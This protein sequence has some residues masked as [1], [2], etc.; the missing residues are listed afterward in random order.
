MLVRVLSGTR[1][2]RVLVHSTGTQ[3][4]RNCSMR[5]CTRWHNQP[6]HNWLHTPHPCTCFLRVQIC[7]LVDM[8]GTAW[9]RRSDLPHP[10]PE[11]PAAHWKP[12]QDIPQ[13]APAH[14]QMWMGVGL[15]VSRLMTRTASA[16]LSMQTM[17]YPAAQRWPRQSVA[18]YAP[19][20]LSPHSSPEQPR[21]QCAP[22]QEPED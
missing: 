5:Q 15:K 4:Q 13:S 7:T 3:F 19:M 22:L 10:S 14:L 12:V 20:L 6:S 16:A 9:R 2:G 1:W 11:H 17:T 21:A 8:C 18:L